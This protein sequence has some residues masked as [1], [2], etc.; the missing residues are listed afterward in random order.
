MET[1]P[2]REIRIANRVNDLI[3]NNAINEVEEIRPS[4]GGKKLASNEDEGISYRIT[5]SRRARQKYH[6][7][8]LSQ[9]R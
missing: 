5:I 2:T 3:K 8:L 9:N 4:L 7:M 1:A 6:E